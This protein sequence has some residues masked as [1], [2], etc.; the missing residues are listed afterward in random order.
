MIANFYIEDKIDRSKYFQE[1]FLVI[2][3]KDEMILRIF[4]FKFNKANISFGNKTLI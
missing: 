4:F 3:I 2:N 1:T